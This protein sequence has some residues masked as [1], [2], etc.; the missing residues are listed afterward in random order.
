M[1]DPQVARFADDHRIVTFDPRGVGKSGR[2][3][4]WRDILS[5]QADDLAALFDELG[6]DRAVVCGVSY[7]GV[8]AQ[9]FALDYP[10]RI[11]GLVV[12]DSFS[13]TRPRSVGA[14]A[15]WLLLYLSG[16]AWL[17]PA[18]MLMPAI[19][20]QYRRWPLALSYLEVDI[21]QLR[22][23]ETTKVRYALN[24]VS[25]TSE[26]DRISCPTLG[27]V[28]TASPALLA[29]MRHLTAAIPKSRLAEVPD[30]FD[31]SNLCQPEEFDR[32]LAGFL[33]EIGWR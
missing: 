17:L 22:K 4:S 7:G 13:D 32:L 11:S 9:R 25:Y 15:Q 19:R 27:I 29:Y 18:G 12:A 33:D 20:R 3:T 1:W 8:L 21:R 28:G 10:A 14:A 23:L 30:S 5:Q 24:G 16:W 26:L 2:L 31:P 6:I